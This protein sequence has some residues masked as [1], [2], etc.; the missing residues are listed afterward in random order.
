MSFAVRSIR[1]AAFASKSFSTLAPKAVVGQNILRLKEI[2]AAADE[3]ALTKISGSALPA[4]D[5]KNIPAELE[6]LRPYFEL[7]NVAVSEP[8][9]PDPTAW[10]N[11]SFWDFAAEE[12]TRAETWP[13]LMGF[14]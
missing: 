13:F 2:G 14:M 5:G 11:K 4:F 10:Q 1:T 9:I 8:F 12:A 7:D 6:Q 3:A